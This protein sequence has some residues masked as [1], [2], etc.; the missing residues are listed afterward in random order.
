MHT[1]LSAPDV[2]SFIFRDRS[3]FMAW[4]PTTSPTPATYLITLQSNTSSSNNIT[5]HHAVDVHVEVPGTATAV[6]FRH[7]PVINDQKYQY[8]LTAVYTQQTSDSV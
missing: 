2:T 4:Q 8:C 3:V 1:G 5:Y 6:E 7:F